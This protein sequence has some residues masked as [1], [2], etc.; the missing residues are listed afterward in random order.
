LLANTGLKC[1]QALGGGVS[2]AAGGFLFNSVG[3]TSNLVTT[4][5]QTS[6]HDSHIASIENRFVDST[7][8]SMTAGSASISFGASSAFGGAFSILDVP[9]ITEL[10]DGLQLLPGAIDLVSFNFTVVVLKSS[11]SRCS[12]SSMSKA[13]RSA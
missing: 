11:F 10:Q 4:A 1:S 3:P 12:A 8:E 5:G 9:Q 7:A 6:V 2:I 13:G